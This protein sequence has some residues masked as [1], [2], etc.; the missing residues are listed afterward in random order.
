MANQIRRQN[1]KIEHSHAMPSVPLKAKTHFDEINESDVWI[2][3]FG[4]VV[5]IA[6]VFVLF[7][8]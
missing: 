3:W 2:Y 6:F 1:P 7:A 4:V 5:A 8:K